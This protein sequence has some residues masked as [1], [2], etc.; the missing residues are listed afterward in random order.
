MDP[1]IGELRIFA[2]NY[3]PEGWALCQG[4]LLN[5]S[6]YDVLFSLLGTTY[7]GD[8]QATFGLPN[9][10]SRVAVG[11]GNGAGLQPYVT[12][13]T[14]GSESVTLNT[15]Q[16][17]SHTHT[18]SQVTVSA[19]TNATTNDP[20]GALFG[21]GTTQIYSTNL[22]STGGLTAADTITGNTSGTGGNQPH[23]NIQPYLAMNYI[24]ALQGLYPPQG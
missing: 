14:G 9:L 1:F 19:G 20:A 16:L 22:P 7:G 5:I 17:P 15:Q 8:G 13:Q 12:G 10:Q 24:I 21:Q 2:G 3:A 4:Q 18:P 23:D 11:A 6:E